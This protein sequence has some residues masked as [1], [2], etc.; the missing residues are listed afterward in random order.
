MYLLHDAQHCVLL[1]DTFLG[2]SFFSPCE[3]YI[4]ILREVVDTCCNRR[5]R[6][7]GKNPIPKMFSV[8][9]F[10]QYE[11]AVLAIMTFQV[12]RRLLPHFLADLFKSCTFFH[13]G[14]SRCL[15]ALSI[16]HVRYWVLSRLSLPSFYVPF[17][18]VLVRILVACLI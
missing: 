4:L 11:I 7:F 18:R 12:G 1:A 6:K 10:F 3:S 14:C 8:F 16:D 9:Y 13:L 2:M 5:V 17:V 15:P